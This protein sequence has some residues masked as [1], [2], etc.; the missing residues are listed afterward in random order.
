MDLGVFRRRRA[1]FWAWLVLPALCDIV[2]YSA[3]HVY[4]RYVED[5]LN[6]REAVLGI[7][8][9]IEQRMAVAKDVVCGFAM[10]GDSQALAA[11]D[12]SSR[13]SELARRHAFTINSLRVKQ[14]IDSVGTTAA[15]PSP[16][17]EIELKGEG[18]LL[19]LMQF[20]NELQSPQHL[21]I[22]DGASIHLGRRRAEAAPKYEVELTVRCFRD[23]LQGEDDG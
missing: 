10:M 7:L 9:D 15:A 14:D 4:C 6:R 19:S 12:V 18:D 1:T 13:I 17:L 2:C 21:S 22:V 11:A 20:L 8:E 3:L 5:R 23:A 16:S